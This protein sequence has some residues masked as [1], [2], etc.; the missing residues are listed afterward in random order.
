[1]I[2]T[3][4]VLPTGLVVKRV[5]DIIDQ[6]QTAIQGDLGSA[7]TLVPNT[8]EGQLMLRCSEQ[9]A[10][11]WELGEMIYNSLFPTSASGVSLDQALSMINVQ[12]I[13]ASASVVNGV[14]I[15]GVYGTVVDTTFQLS[16][17]GNPSAIFQLN[18]EVTIGADGTVLGDFVC[19]T[20]GPIEAPAGK[21]TNIVTAVV[22]V[23]SCTNVLPGQVG[24]V[25]E[26]DAAYRVRALLEQNQPGTGTFNGLLRSVRSVANVS[27]VFLFSR[28]ADTAGAAQ[29]YTAT[30]TAHANTVYSVK[31][32]GAT[33]SITSGSGATK[34]SIAAALL[35][36]ITDLNVTVTVGGSDT[37]VITAKNVGTFFTFALVTTNMTALETTAGG[38]LPHSVLLIVVGGVDQDIY[39][40]IFAAK[41]AGINTNGTQ[42]GTVYDSQGVSHSVLFARLTYVPIYM[43]IALTVNTD[44]SSGP[45]FP[46]N[47]IQQ[48]KSAVLAFAADY[49]AGETVVLGAF[50]SPVYSVPGV[51][52]ATITMGIFPTPTA[53][54][55]VVMSPNEAAQFLVGNLSV[56]AA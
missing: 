4:G 48:V 41:P 30:I 25:A 27:Q 53:N 8:P 20:T 7:F 33:Y 23:T 19:I 9:V 22:G 29:V 26:S 45:V 55:N 50:N 40:M 16:V 52:A 11:L 32:N 28:D 54:A 51:T 39:D 37:L 6:E 34:A 18:A 31:V 47:G 56:T 21:L 36:A 43:N 42:T 14:T 5:S 38:L 46:A 10:D 13:P 12:R 49:V 35:A 3:F 44:P 24:A 17:D 15:S 1:M 2:G